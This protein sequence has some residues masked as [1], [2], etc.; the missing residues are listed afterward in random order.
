MFSTLCRPYKEG[1]PERTVASIR[2]ILDRCGLQPRITF[3]ANPF[4][5]VYSVSLQMDSAEGG[6]RSNGKGRTEALCVASAYAEFMERLQNGL[7]LSLP[8][9]I[10]DQLHRNLGFYYAPD[11]RRLGRTEFLA[12]PEAVRADLVRYRGAAMDLFIDAYFDRLDTRGASGAVA[13][14]FYSTVERK[15]VYLPLNMLLL[16]VGSNGMA[17]GN[18]LEEATFQ[19]LC[20]LLER[21]GASEVFYRQLTP[22]TVPDSFLC[23]FEEEY[24]IIQAIQSRGK[25]QVT[26][27]DFSAGRR[28]PAIGVMVENLEKE[29]YR[30]N[31]GCDT[32]FQ[33]ALSRGLTEIFQGFA[34]EEMIDRRLLPIPK[35]DAACFR[36]TDEQSLYARYVIFTQFTKDNSGIFPASLFGPEPS[37]NFDPSV[38]EQRPSYREEAQRLIGFLHRQGHNVYIRDVS[39]LGFP[40]V[41]VYVPEIS[42]LGRKDAGVKFAQTFDVIEWDKVE[43]KLCAIA[44]LSKDD[45]IAIANTLMSLPGHLPVTQ[46]LG[47][48]LRDDSPWARLPVSFL[49]AQ[50][51]CKVEKWK[52][53][54]QAFESFHGGRKDGNRYYDVLGQYL[55]LRAKGLSPEETFA[56]LAAS[57]E[58]E[59]VRQVCSDMAEPDHVF[60]NVSLPGCPNCEQCRLEADCVTKVQL[61]I[62]RHIYPMMQCG[63]PRQSHAWTSSD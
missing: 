49:L 14:P 30:L 57:S 33:V 24:Q 42:A 59:V 41:F 44:S 36:A 20:E 55:E 3:N 51:W 10:G 40:S 16:C 43:E 54:S 4:P 32:C 21:W 7:Y 60:A 35:E 34:D 50:I 58:S 11:E 39:S 52:E 38:F 6:F 31:V 47:L 48:K 53:A 63:M 22:P 23:R 45:A 26:V 62:A 25:Y 18:S 1:A 56:R 9:V 61:G 5:Q 15:E 8:R 13:V 29:T 17:A 28:I 37:Y 12:L 19:A 2:R 27:K 46:L